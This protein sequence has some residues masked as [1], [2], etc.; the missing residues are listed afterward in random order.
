MPTRRPE[1]SLG[2]T[3]RGARARHGTL[4][5]RERGGGNRIFFRLSKIR[6]PS[7]PLL[8]PSYPLLPPP[9][10]VTG[11][12]FWGGLGVA[13]WALGVARRGGG[14][15]GVLCAG[16]ADSAQHPRRLPRNKQ[17]N[18]Q[19]ARRLTNQRH[20]SRGGRGRGRDEGRA[21]RGKAR[22]RRAARAPHT[23]PSTP[24][25][26]STGGPART[27]SHRRRSRKKP[28]THMPVP[29]ITLAQT[30]HGT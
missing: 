6:D 7:Y 1:K 2:E 12:R 21:D 27:P 9:A 28:R 8:P 3:K 13:R 5:G 14:S 10:P 15:A 20:T 22:T 19:N 30:G 16:G 4:V 29:P 11:A 25:S 18:K 24:T 17:T 26:T 23:Q